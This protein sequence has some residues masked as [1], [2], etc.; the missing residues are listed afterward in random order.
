MILKFRPRWPWKQPLNLR[1]LKIHPVDFIL[2]YIFDISGFHWS[3]WAIDCLI[4]KNFIFQI[5][6]QPGCWKFC[7]ICLTLILKSAQARCGN[8]TGYFWNL[9]QKNKFLKFPHWFQ[10]SLRDPFDQSETIQTFQRSPAP[11]TNNCRE[12]SFFGRT[13]HITGSSSTSLSDPG[14]P[15][16]IHPWIY[17]GVSWL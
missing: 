8:A 16:S 14:K 6:Y 11:K 4:W 9:R 5:C 3:K 13:V 2:N 12:N 17:S 15:I 7:P 1:S 10:M